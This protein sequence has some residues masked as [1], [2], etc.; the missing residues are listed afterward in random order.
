MADPAQP[1]EIHLASPRYLSPVCWS[2]QS[3]GI[4][5]FEGLEASEEIDMVDF[6]RDLH[7]ELC[8]PPY[9]IL[10]TLAAFNTMALRF[11]QKEQKL[12]NPFISTCMIVSSIIETSPRLS[13]SPHSREARRDT[14]EEAYSFFRTIDVAYRTYIAQKTSSLTNHSA[15]MLVKLIGDAYELCAKALPD[16]ADNICQTLKIDVA[17][18]TPVEMVPAVIRQ[19]WRLRTF[20]KQIRDGR[21][22]MRV[23]GIESMQKDLVT[24][25]RNHLSGDVAGVTNPIV[26]TA[27]RFLQSSRLIEYLVGVDSHE[28]LISRTPNI[29]AFMILTDTYTKADTDTIWRAVIDGHDSRVVP[30]LLKM[31]TQTFTYHKSTSN[32]LFDLCQK[33]VETPLDCFDATLLDYTNR[34]LRDIKDL[35]AG[36]RRSLAAEAIVE[37]HSEDNDRDVVPLKLCS[38]LMRETSIAATLTP[39]QKHILQNF[40]NKHIAS[41]LE[42]ESPNDYIFDTY[43]QCIQDVIAPNAYTFGSIRLLYALLTARGAQDLEHL[44]QAYNLTQVVIDELA[45]FCASVRQSP[46]AISG[47][48]HLYPRVGLIYFII[49]NNPQSLTPALCDKFW[50]QI[51][52]LGTFCDRTRNMVFD[53]LT[54]ATQAAIT[55][56]TRNPV[57]E[58]IFATKLLTIPPEQ[59]SMNVLNLVTKAVVYH[60]HLDKVSQVASDPEPERSISIPCMDQMWRIITTAKPNT[61]EL[62]AIDRAIDLYLDHPSARAAGDRQVDGLH[63]ALVDKCIRE[64]I[65]AATHLRRSQPTRSGTTVAQPATNL[66]EQELQFSRQLLF[67]KQLIKNLESRPHRGSTPAQPNAVDHA[68]DTIEVA[69]QTFAGATSSGVQTLRISRNDTA[70]QLVDTIT[71][72][73]KF[74]RFST[75]MGG[76]R[77]D[78]AETPS[79][80]IAELRVGQLGLLMIRK[81]PDAEIIQ[82]DPGEDPIALKVLEHFEPLYDLLD[83]VA[84]VAKEIYDLL[85][86]F[87]PQ[88]R[89]LALVHDAQA[90]IEIVLPPQIPFKAWYSLIAIRSSLESERRADAPD[91]HFVNHVV[92]LLTTFFTSIDLA[93]A[94]QTP[95]E[96]VWLNVARATVDNLA[97]ALDIALK[98]QSLAVPRDSGGFVRAAINIVSCAAPLKSESDAVEDVSA[99]LQT[100]AFGIALRA[101]ECGLVSW[102]ASKRQPELSD[103]MAILLVQD[104]RAHVRQAICGTIEDLCNLDSV[105]QPQ[106]TNLER[107]KQILVS[108]WSAVEPLITR[109]RQFPAAY[110][111]FFCVANALLRSICENGLADLDLPKILRQWQDILAHYQPDE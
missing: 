81:H 57:L 3:T 37:I 105:P 84:Q 12:V 72:L 82:A 32:G 36:R 5:L 49:E 28:Q 56:E 40:A 2:L 67:L 13:S 96:L 27:A 79:R 14:L 110:E 58:R 107:R 46:D 15:E 30:A 26:Q 24:L 64:L 43:S 11:I 4:P 88:Q 53:M 111:E 47:F 80:T 78:F 29:I 89:I 8:K 99:D 66:D 77:V 85:I 59:F 93:A 20:E 23:L 50:R 1:D 51:F 70:Q 71:R 35:L 108:L 101:A 69:Y 9:S 44:I 90:P 97:M 18:D 65:S 104:R 48:H 76:R 83:S 6:M 102:G 92:D 62:T 54:K 21:M 95:D 98:G 17:H 109:T 25:W 33:L 39:E 19:S 31:L 60:V 86:F 94:H 10:Q 42:A 61:I 38:R 41:L 87:P 7:A 73:T 100:K 63:V 55:K 106:V 74:S 91:L 16:L 75:Y 45:H 68:D 34:L 103:V 52:D 22:E